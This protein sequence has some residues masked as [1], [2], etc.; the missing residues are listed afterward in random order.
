MR[1]SVQEPKKNVQCY[2]MDFLQLYPAGH[3]TRDPDNHPCMNTAQ[4]YRAKF[5]SVTSLFLMFQ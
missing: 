5:A 2:Q 4:M 1:L 3:K